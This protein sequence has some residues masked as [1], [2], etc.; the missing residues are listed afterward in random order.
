[1]ILIKNGLIDVLNKDQK[2]L[3]MIEDNNNYSN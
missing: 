2:Q 1:M 3:F